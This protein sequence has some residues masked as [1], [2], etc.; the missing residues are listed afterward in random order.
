MSGLFESL[1]IN[2]KSV[3]DAIDA[4]NTEAVRSRLDLP[5][6]WQISLPVDDETN[7]L[8]A[9]ACKLAGSK[10]EKSVT[11][12]HLATAIVDSESCAARQVLD[13]L[14]V[15]PENLKSLLAATGGA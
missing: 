1:G 9:S 3:R 11:V 13:V 12:R 15:D 14:R 2:T 6:S 7:D 8:I 4:I 10:D 5:G